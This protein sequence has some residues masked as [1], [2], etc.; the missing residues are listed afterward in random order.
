MGGLNASVLTSDYKK[1]NTI[2]TGIGL[3]SRETEILRDLNKGFSRS[4]IAANQNLSINTVRLI[5]NTI[6][7]KLRARNIADLIRIAHEQKLI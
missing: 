1:V 5:I 2:D 3:S 6:Y 4:E 7:E